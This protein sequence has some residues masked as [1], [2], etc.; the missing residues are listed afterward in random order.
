MPTPAALARTLLRPPRLGLPR[1]ADRLTVAAFVAFLA[2][3]LVAAVVRPPRQPENEKRP[4]N[5]PPYFPDQRWKAQSFPAMFDAYYKDRVGFRPELL[6][7][8]RQILV[9]RL[10]DPTADGVWIGRD[11][12]LFVNCVGPLEVRQNAD[13]RL[14]A[15][16]AG[17]EERRK[18][19]AARGIGFVVVVVPEKASVYPEFLPATAR[20]H[21]PPDYLGQLRALA[22]SVTAVDPLPA[23]LAAKAGPDPLFYRT[24]THWTSAGAF[25]AYA[26]LGPALAAFLPGYRPKPLDRIARFPKQADGCDLAVMLGRPVAACVEDTHWLYEQDRDSYLRPNAAVVELMNRRPDRLKHVTPAVSE[27]PHGVGRVV[28]LHDSFGDNLRELMW[29]DFRR[30]VAVGTYGLPTDLIEA[31]RPDVVVQLLVARY[32]VFPRPGDE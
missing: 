3:P 26:D 21:P 30:F 13:R 5:P 12:W 20:R 22:P 15:R 6:D 4:L 28:L 25:A 24:D 14:R 18:W 7:L 2:V 31:E 16:A 1:L 9:E 17:L 23:M 27:A 10:G 8:R 29:S 19:L 32:L 11:G